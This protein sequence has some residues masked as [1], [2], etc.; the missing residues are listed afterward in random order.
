MK[1]YYCQT[2]TYAYLE[3]FLQY[4]TIITK[5]S[6]AC[7]LPPDVPRSIRPQCKL[8]FWCLELLGEKKI[9]VVKKNFWKIRVSKFLFQKFSI[10]KKFFFPVFPKFFNKKI[11]FMSNLSS[12][13]FE[14]SFDVYIVCVWSKNK[15][16]TKFSYQIWANFYYRST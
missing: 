14:L 13:L 16:F 12:V 5:V 1:K 7:H 2:Y 11:F 10:E 15:V 4:I 9:G 6:W 8:V 3:L